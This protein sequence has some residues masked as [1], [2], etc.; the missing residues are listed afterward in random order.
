MKNAPL[1]TGAFFHSKAFNLFEAIKFIE[2]FAI[3]IRFWRPSGA[4]P[5]SKRQQVRID[6]PR[7]LA[8]G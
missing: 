4:A 3:C 8:R 1:S 6:G 5:I 7:E 2:T